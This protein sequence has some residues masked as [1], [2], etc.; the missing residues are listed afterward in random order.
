MRVATLYRGNKSLRLP[1]NTNDKKGLIYFFIF[2]WL[3]FFTYV[4]IGYLIYFFYD[5]I[6][7]SGSLISL[8]LLF[9][10]PVLTSYLYLAY[11]LIKR[12]RYKILFSLFL[13]PFPTIFFALLLISPF[14]YLFF[15]SFSYINLL[16]MNSNSDKKK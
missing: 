12:I 13:L 4:C 15:L 7:S 5:D 16:I 10:L 3:S 14:I 2:L 11:E 9:S 1:D 6:K 8:L